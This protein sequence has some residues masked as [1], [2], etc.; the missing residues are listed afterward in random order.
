MFALTCKWNAAMFEM[1]KPGPKEVPSASTAKSSKPSSTSA[2]TTSA[3]KKGSAKKPRKAAVKQSDLMHLIPVL[4]RLKKWMPPRYRLCYECLR[5]RR[6]DLVR[7]AFIKDKGRIR[8]SWTPGVTME[9]K[10]RVTVKAVRQNGAHCPE[11]GVRRK[12]EV[13]TIKGEFKELKQMISDMAGV[14]S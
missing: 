3:D 7:E 5:F 4:Q 6:K 13:L 10:K 14:N 2:G 1:L 11:C 8:G 9:L 12:L